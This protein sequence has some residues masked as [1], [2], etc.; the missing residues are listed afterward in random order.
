VGSGVGV[1]VGVG[2]GVAII[3]KTQVRKIA[4]GTRKQTYGLASA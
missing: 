3:Q 2:S 1:G 4:G